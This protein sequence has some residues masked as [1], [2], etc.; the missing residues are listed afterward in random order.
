MM[1]GLLLAALTAPLGLPA[2]GAAQE[3]PPTLTDISAGTASDSAV[4]TDGNVNGRGVD[5]PDGPGNSV[6]TPGT[7]NGVPVT[8]STPPGSISPSVSESTTDPDGS[9]IEAAPPEAAPAAPPEAAPGEGRGNRG[10]AGA[11]GS[12]AAGAG[13]GSPTVGGNEIPPAPAPASNAAPTSDGS[14]GGAAPATG[15]ACGYPTWLDAQTA[16]E[17]DPDLAPELDPDGDGIACE[18]AMV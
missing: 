6:V 18:E 11:D 15:D 17:K 12:T 14:G 9:T 16:F 5:L 2:T 4:G 1:T 7:V 3:A 13:T 8:S 10:N